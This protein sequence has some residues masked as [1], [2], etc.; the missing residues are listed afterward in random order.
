MS[1]KR[2]FIKLL[3]FSIPF[4]CFV[5]L[6]LF[7]DPF[8]VVRQYDSY[9]N[10]GQPNYIS[11]NKDHI[12]TQN[13]LNHHNKYGYDSYIFG[14]SRSL[15]YEVNT[16]KDY[17]GVP[18]QKCYHFDASGESIYGIAK[19]FEFLDRQQAK[20]KNALVVIDGELL[21]KA[22]NS[23]GHLF[24]KDP[25][26][27]GDHKFKFQLESIKAFFD[28]KFLTS[29][30][31]FKMSGQIKE[32]MKKEFLLDDR[33]FYYDNVTNEIQQ[34]QYE[35]IIKNNPTA[36]YEP[37]KDVFYA[38][39]TTKQ[40]VTPKVI[41]EAQ[42]QLLSSIKNILQ[43]NKTNYRIVISPLYDQK[44]LNPEDLKILKDT[45]GEKNV[46]DFSGINDFTKD[47][48]NYY[49]TSHYR[50]HIAAA[51]MRIIYSDNN[52]ITG[53]PLV[54]NETHLPKN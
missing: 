8:K 15:Y 4:V 9:Y 43:K 35:G 12:S 40:Q 54:N 16:W 48:H 31:D 37:R 23:A 1:I 41:R 20:I 46:F 33:T 44:K 52:T 45:F 13:W 17:I 2:L 47:F 50:P 39:D 30:L 36:F 6:Y 18:Y 19:K 38:R 10:S 11:L 53:L 26:I 22:D 25:N 14:N 3:L 29:F 27:S 5:L 7:M 42:L 32:Y 24:L 49:E 28:F 34:Q 21:N 51:V